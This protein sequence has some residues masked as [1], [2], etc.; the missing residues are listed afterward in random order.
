[1]RRTDKDCRLMPWWQLLGARHERVHRDLV[2]DPD[3]RS[4]RIAKLKRAQA[5][6][7]ARGDVV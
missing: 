4:V 7:R 5:L 1:M 3:K 2:T 6:R